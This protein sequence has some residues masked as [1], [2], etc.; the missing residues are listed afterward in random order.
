MIYENDT[1]VL[2]NNALRTQIINFQLLFIIRMP[3]VQVVEH[4]T[5]LFGITTAD[6]FGVR[7]SI[8]G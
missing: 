8:Y 7:F 6:L 4:K 1:S 3:E 2:K 5:V